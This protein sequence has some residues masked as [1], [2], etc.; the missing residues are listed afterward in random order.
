M[1][2]MKPWL[3]LNIS[4]SNF[5]CNPL[6]RW[7]AHPYRASNGILD[8]EAS[9]DA[10]KNIL[11]VLCANGGAAIQPS[12]RRTLQGLY[13]IWSAGFPLY[14]GGFVVRTGRTVLYTGCCHD[15]NTFT[16]DLDALERMAEG[17]YDPW[18]GHDPN[19]TAQYRDGYIWFYNAESRRRKSGASFTSIEFHARA[20]SARWDLYRFTWGPFRELLSQLAPGLADGLLELWCQNL[21]I[22]EPPALW[23]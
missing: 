17:G 12:A 4:K 21:H 15:L 8:G 13:H 18:L 20:W 10:V 1:R 6:P 19:L 22:E 7:L 3:D 2:M 5:W 16:E 11:Y 23:Y 14:Q 9:E